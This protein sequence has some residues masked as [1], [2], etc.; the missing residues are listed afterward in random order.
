MK[1]SEL[2]KLPKEARYYILEQGVI[3]VEQAAKVK[4]LEKENENYVQIMNSYLRKVVALEAEIKKLAPYK[5]NLE[6]CNGA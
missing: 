1:P 2:L 4:Y 3:I 5:G 6:G